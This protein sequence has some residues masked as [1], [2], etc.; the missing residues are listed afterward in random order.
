MAKKM[1]LK[2]A[3][4]ILMKAASNDARGS[5][6]GFRSTT[7]DWR[8]QLSEAWAVA[9]KRVYGWEPTDSE[10]F[11]AGLM[12]PRAY[13]PPEPAAAT[14]E[15]ATGPAKNRKDSHGTD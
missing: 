8:R 13:V 3:L 14:N 5:G 1:S 12:P 9:H 4:R 2:E 7:D 11:N 6:L 15:G 10:F